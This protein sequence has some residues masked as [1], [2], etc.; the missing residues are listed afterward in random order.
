[1]K[2]IPAAVALALSL[3]SVQA[4]DLL[5][6]VAD[7]LQGEWGQIKTDIRY[8]YEYVDPEGK[9][10]EAHASTMRLRLGYLTPKF[11][12]LQ[13][14]VEMEGNWELGL[15]RYN[16]IRN[17]RPYAVVADPQETELNQGWVSYTVTEGVTI[18]AGRQRII[19]DDHRFIGNV[20][21]RQLEQTYD[22]VTIH[23]E[24]LP[25]AVIEAAFIW[26]VQNILSRTIDMTSPLL[27]ITYT[28][29]P[30]GKISAYGYW[31]DYDDRKDSANFTLS[32]QTYGIRFDGKHAL[33]D[34]LDG[35]YHLEYAHQM[36]YQ[37]NPNDFSTDYYR[38]MA[39]L[40]AYGITIKGAVENLTADNNVGFAMPLATLHAFQGWADKFL[41]TPENGVRDVYATVA[42]KLWG[43]KLMGV[44]HDFQDENGDERYGEEYDAL[45]TRKFGQHFSVLLKYAYYNAKG[46]STDTQKVWGQVAMHF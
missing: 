41:K 44:Y 26:R 46:F 39:G 34:W 6:P 24:L 20:G 9:T 29:L 18:K 32:T 16:S 42:V 21:W 14:Y 7:A 10:E 38:F 31:L 15:D 27:H 11:K 36:D 3:G 17:R 13:G 23:N 30:F 2:K 22:A 5:K 8:R 12:G 1:M 4:E 25:D 28:G 45:L 40:S 37:R 43:T 33:T 35:L 19:H